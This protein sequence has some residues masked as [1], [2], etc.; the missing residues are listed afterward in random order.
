MSQPPPNDPGPDKPKKCCFGW[1]KKLSW[2]EKI[3]FL[4]WISAS[5]AA[6]FTLYLAI[7]AKETEKTQLRAYVS[8]KPSQK[9][10]TNFGSSMDAEL[11]LGIQNSGQTPAIDL[12]NLSILFPRPYPLPE[13][14]DLT[15]PAPSGKPPDGITLHPRDV[16]YGS[17]LTRK[18]EPLQYAAIKAGVGRLYAFGTIYYNDVF[19]TAHW[20]HFCYS[21]YGEGPTLT[22][23]ESCPRYNDT[24]KN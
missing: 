8:A 13:N 11:E 2:A 9:G 15:I 10:I 6:A 17:T 23:W 16:E 20:T 12:T 22:K 1:A 14:I 19:G 3:Q 5:A 7:I 18:V 21:F 4:I 24:D